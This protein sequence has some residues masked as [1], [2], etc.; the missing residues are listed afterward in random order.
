[1]PGQTFDIGG[2][3]LHM[4]CAGNGS[5]TVV[6]LS[7]T[8]EMSASWARIVPEVASNTRVCAYDRAGQGWSD[9]A[10][11]PQDGNEMAA[12]LHQLLAV[13]GE[14]GPYLLAGH[15]LGG[16]YSL[17][18]AAKYP[19]DVAGVAL[20]D[21]SSPEQFALPGLQRPV[22]DDPPRLQRPSIRRTARPRPTGQ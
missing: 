12:D 3:S 11:H 20:L 9:D 19:D 7:G 14:H 15:S 5:P 16:V 4:T 2:R 8:G 18:F 10:P 1:M 21:S 13:A 6:L 22:P 17:A